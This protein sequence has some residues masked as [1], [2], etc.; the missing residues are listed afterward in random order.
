MGQ[1]FRSPLP[2]HATDRTSNLPSPCTADPGPHQIPHAR[3]FLAGNCWPLFPPSHFTMCPVSAGPQDF[4]LLSPSLALILQ[5]PF[6]FLSLLWV[7]T[8]PF[9]TPAVSQKQQT[10]VRCLHSPRVRNAEKYDL[11]GATFQENEK[12]VA[13]QCHF[14]SQP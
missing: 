4:P 1:G 3:C 14:L 11:L 6:A 12:P 10:P 9:L 13:A 7:P 2:S 8:L 5:L